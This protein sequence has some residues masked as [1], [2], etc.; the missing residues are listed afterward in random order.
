MLIAELRKLPRKQA[1]AITLRY[2]EGLSVAEAAQLMGVEQG[3]VKSLCSR[4]LEQLKQNSNLQQLHFGSHLAT[5][6]AND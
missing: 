6:L 1:T 4:G 3:T 2:T 5:E